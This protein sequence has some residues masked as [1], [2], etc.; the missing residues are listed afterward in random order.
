M[1]YGKILEQIKPT[2]EEIRK[3]MK[4]AKD[5]INEI[6][7]LG[8]EAVL[9]GS[10]ARNTFLRN[11]GDLDIFVFFPKN[12]NRERFEKL[13]LKVGKT[14]LKKHKARV[15]YAEHPY[16]KGIINGIDIDVVPCY[17]IG[18]GEKIISSVDRTPLHNEY[19]SK[20]VK[21]FEDQILL[22]KQFMKGSRCYGANEKVQGFS[23]IMCEFLIIEYKTFDKVIEVA[24]KKW[25]KK[26]IL[27]AKEKDVKRF[28][29]QMVVID[30][31]DKNRNM[32]AAVSRKSL[33]KFM[34]K[35]R[36]FLKKPTKDF[37]FPKPVKFNP[38]KLIKERSLVAI[39]FAYPGKVIEEIVWGQLRKLV[40]L[41]KM[42][43]E[44]EGFTILHTFFWTDEKR[45]CVILI[46]VENKILN[47]F[48]RRRGPEVFDSDNAQK[49]IEKHKEVWVEKNRVFAWHKRKYVNIIDFLKYMLQRETMPSHLQRVVSRAKVLQDKELLRIKHVL[50]EDMNELS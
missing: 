2:G 6:N 21:G 26:I 3:T 33:T 5:L 39:D 47:Q 23:G 18:D 35:A 40:K 29:E 45:Q 31:V 28:K 42:K 34:L 17:K 38:K 49:F 14:V 27:N 41:I 15:H 20:K 11:S 48:K 25:D 37:F 4:V 13:G 8:Y 43:L 44:G 16:I 32:A 50:Q 7:K 19:F 10:S 30:P 22:L 9:V 46:E 36:Q 24:A 12:I 1:K